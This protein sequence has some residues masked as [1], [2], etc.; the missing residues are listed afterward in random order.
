MVAQLDELCRKTEGLQYEIIVADDGSSDKTAI[1]AN[2]CINDFEH[3]R[4]IERETNEGAGATRNFLTRESQYNWLLFVDC[5]MVVPNEHFISRYLECNAEAV[6][7][8]GIA[9]EGNMQRNN[10]RFLY[11]K[12]A[13]SKHTAAQR[14]LQP[15]KS[16]RSTNFLAPREVMLCNPFYGPMK[17][18][19][20]VYFGKILKQ[21]KV[22]ILHIDNPLMMID[23]DTNAEY[24]NK[25]E[26]DMA[27][28]HRFRRELKGYSPLLTAVDTLK[29]WVV[30]IWLWRLFH[31]LFGGI[32]RQNLTSGRPFLCLLNTYK[33][34]YFLCIRD[35]AI[36]K[37]L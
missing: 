30:P 29:H 34:G 21:R 9:I 35:K 26:K 13:E 14:T 19:E 18:Y 3:C 33:M 11:E 12:K 27:T 25:V 28:L 15:Y 23:F 6:I 16:F 8:G 17:R 20:D 32:I 37:R 2:R 7:N 31:R 4:F 1:E 24:I 5:D 36:R 22:E 10:L